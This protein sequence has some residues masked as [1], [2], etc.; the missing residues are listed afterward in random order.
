MAPPL[1]T[2]MLSLYHGQTLPA[3]RRRRERAD[4]APRQ[5]IHGSPRPPAACVNR[6]QLIVLGDA[7]QKDTKKLKLRFP[8]ISTM[9]EQRKKLPIHQHGVS[10]GMKKSWKLLSEGHCAR[11]YLKG[12]S[13]N[14]CCGSG[15]G[16]RCLFDPWIRDPGS[17]IGFFPDP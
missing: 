7:V 14:Q 5:Q 3:P 6:K 13:H 11:M 8:W 4:P 1:L 12:L 2:W 16:I 9:N 10:G 15:S 17:G